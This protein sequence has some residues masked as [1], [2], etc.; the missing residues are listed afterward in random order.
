MVEPVIRSLVSERVPVA[1]RREVEASHSP[2]WALVLID[3]T[4]IFSLLS[5]RSGCCLKD[6][7]QSVV[8]PLRLVHHAGCSL[9]S[10]ALPLMRR[11]RV[12]LAAW[13]AP[14]RPLAWLPALQLF[15][16][17]LQLLNLL[18]LCHNSHFKV[19]NVA[20]ALCR[21]L[22]SRGHVR[23]AEVIADLLGDDPRRASLMSCCTPMVHLLF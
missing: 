11:F 15:K 2:V 21:P 22:A 10:A 3:F 13:A 20:G 18:N 4:R 8:A 19:I 5:F 7:K 1:S 16:Y 12:A 14:N 23:L 6:V 9:Q 17:F